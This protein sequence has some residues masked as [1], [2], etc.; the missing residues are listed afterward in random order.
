[1]EKKKGKNKTKDKRPLPFLGSLSGYLGPV[2][3]RIIASMEAWEKLRLYVLADK[4]FPDNFYNDIVWPVIKKHRRIGTIS[5]S[6]KRDITFRVLKIQA[7]LFYLFFDYWL[8]NDKDKLKCLKEIK[9]IAKEV[10]KIKKINADSDSYLY[11][12]LSMHAIHNRL[13]TENKVLFFKKEEAHPSEK[14]SNIRITYVNDGKKILKAILNGNV[15]SLVSLYQLLILLESYIERMKKS[16]YPDILIFA[17]NLVAASYLFFDP[18][19]GNNPFGNPE[20]L[21]EDFKKVLSKA[22]SIFSPIL[23]F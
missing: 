21:N 12:A 4:K 16:K 13:L 14:D 17:Y 10:S 7:A 18:Q 15:D 2:P 8:K 6:E 19:H 3:L 5:K 20:K 23:K 22:H 9:E 11:A 1:M